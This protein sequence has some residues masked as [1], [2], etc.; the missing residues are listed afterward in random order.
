VAFAVLN[1]TGDQ[2]FA[3]SHPLKQ[4]QARNKA[5][6]LTEGL[7]RLLRNAWAEISLMASYIAAR[8]WF[9]CVEGWGMAAA[10]RVLCSVQLFREVFAVH[11]S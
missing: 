7:V 10:G 9:G 2:G 1:G 3:D 5:T 6:L 11:F 8:S 4:D